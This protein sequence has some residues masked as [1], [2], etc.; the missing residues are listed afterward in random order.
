MAAI[1]AYVET[2]LRIAKQERQFAQ[3]QATE[4]KLGGIIRVLEI[5]LALINDK[6]N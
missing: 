4:I 1:R 6:P 2:A 5:A 3:T